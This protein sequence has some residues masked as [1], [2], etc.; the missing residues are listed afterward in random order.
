MA[1]LTLLAIGMVHGGE[2]SRS[3]AKEPSSARATVRST[4]NSAIGEWEAATA[5]TVSLDAKGMIASQLSAYASEGVPAVATPFLAKAY[6]YEVR[7]RQQMTGAP[8]KNLGL[9]NLESYP[10]NGFVAQ[11]VL[12]KKVGFLRCWADPKR[13]AGTITIDGVASG[14]TIKEFVLSIGKHK[15]SIQ[16][17]RQRCE[18]EIIVEENR[19]IEMR[20]PNK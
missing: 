3:T 10:L 14:D 4:V 15:A 1:A 18:E 2:S 7:D 20:C 17:Q 5:V 12:G 9:A 19:L 16:L 6:L 8:P 11:S 13:K